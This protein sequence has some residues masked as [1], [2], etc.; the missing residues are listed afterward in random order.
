MAAIEPVGRPVDV[1]AAAP[2]DLMAVTAVDTIHTSFV[3]MVAASVDPVDS[4]GTGTATTRGQQTAGQTQQRSADPARPGEGSRP[5]AQETYVLLII[6]RVV[7]AAALGVV[8]ADRDLDALG[9]EALAELGALLDAGEL[10]GGPDGE[11]LREG[12]GEDGAGT[13]VERPLGGAADIDEGEFEAT[14]C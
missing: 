3:V 14:C 7:L 8:L 10:L 12:F 11:G 6:V 9:G 1:V 4:V 13:G 5:V 2:T